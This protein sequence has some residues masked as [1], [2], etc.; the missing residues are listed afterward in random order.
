MWGVLEVI[1]YWGKFL[2][3]VTFTALTDS[4]NWELETQSGQG[5]QLHYFFAIS[6]ENK[7][8]TWSWT[9]TFPQLS[10]KKYP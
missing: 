4:Y 7:F 5:S 1:V 8:Y 3:L 6:F 2:S 9:I 10:N